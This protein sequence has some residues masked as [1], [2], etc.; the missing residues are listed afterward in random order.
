MKKN[1]LIL[2]A[3]D[4][5]QPETMTYRWDKKIDITIFSSFHANEAI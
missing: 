4:Q 3:E 5:K 2:H 1:G